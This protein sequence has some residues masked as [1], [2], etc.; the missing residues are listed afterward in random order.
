MSMVRFHINGLRCDDDA[1]CETHAE[2]SLE[3]WS[4]KQRRSAQ[5]R[6]KGAERHMMKLTHVA[7]TPIPRNPARMYKNVWRVTR[8]DDEEFRVETWRNA[9]NGRLYSKCGCGE[10]E[11]D[12]ARFVKQHES[13]WTLGFSG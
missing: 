5:G 3:R 11:C 12:H 2:V 1:C 6:W 7:S 4:G 13:K 8:A 10:H 9:P